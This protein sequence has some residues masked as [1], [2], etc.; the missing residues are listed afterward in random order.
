MPGI[1]DIS[2][3][4]DSTT[5][6]WPGLEG[7]HIDPAERMAR[8]DAVNVTNLRFCAH[9]GTHV[10]APFHHFADGAGVDRIPMAG[11]VGPAVVADLISVSAGISARDLER[12]LP[13]L[14]AQIV[15]LKTRNST[16][17]HTALQWQDNYVYL[18]PDGAE[19]LKGRGVCGVG[20]D[21]LG[22]ERYGRADGA[23][24]KILLGASIAILEGLDLRAVEP[25][26][27]WL[28]CLPLKLPRIDGAPARAVLID[29]STGAFMSA[30]TA[31]GADAE[32]SRP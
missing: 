24:H 9:T 27:Y 8:S 31:S 12:A 2:L 5:V 3:P 30:W 13:V 18:E 10:D 6:I 4:L 28:A 19:W 1:I 15:L 21:A 32:R 29:D 25:G 7:V 17:L 26:L 11:L 23:T 14:Q 16:E 22:I 20:I